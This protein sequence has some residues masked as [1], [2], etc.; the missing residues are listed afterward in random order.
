[1]PASSRKLKPGAT[2]VGFLAPHIQA[3]L[4][5]ALKEQNITSFAMELVP[6]IS[7]AQSM[8][9]LSSQAAVAGYK[10]VLI[11]APHSTSSSRC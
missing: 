1:M 3:P 4:V 9:A 8:D 5:R 2:V 10:A 7:R 6:R 11:G